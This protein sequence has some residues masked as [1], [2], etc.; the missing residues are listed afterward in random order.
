MHYKGPAKTA[1]GC[2]GRLK[3]CGSATCYVQGLTFGGRCDPDAMVPCKGAG[4]SA[5]IRSYR[6][7]FTLTSD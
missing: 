3:E 6:R 1:P 7:L 2:I 4:L 5:P